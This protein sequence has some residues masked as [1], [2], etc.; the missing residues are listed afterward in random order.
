MYTTYSSKI[1]FFFQGAM[2]Q[3]YPSQHIRSNIFFATYLTE[4]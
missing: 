1:T 4:K 3:S 2:D